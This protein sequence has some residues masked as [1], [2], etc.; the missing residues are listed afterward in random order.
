MRVYFSNLGCKLNQAEVDRMA[1]SFVAAGHQLA[2]ELEQADLHVINSCTVT[3]LAGRDSRKTARRG[4]RAGVRTVLTG[5]HAT[6]APE[7]AAGLGVDLVLPNAQKDELLERVHAAFPELQPAPGTSFSPY[8]P[9]EVGHQ[10]ALVKIEDGCNMGCAFCIIPSTRGRQQSR[11]PAEVLAEVEALSAAGFPEIVLTGVQ[12]SEYL[13]GGGSDGGGMRL[14]DLVLYL[15]AKSGVHRLRLTSIAPWRFDPRLLELYAHPRICRHIHLSLQSGST[16][17]LRRMRRPYSPE[18]FAA[19]VARLREAVPGIA[20]TT[21]IIVGFPGESMA[22]H[23]ESLAFALSQQFAKTHVFTYSPRPGTLAAELPGEV[24][25][26]EAKRR[27]HQQ[28]AVAA[29]SERA[30]AAQSVGQRLAVIWDEQRGPFSTGLADTSLR[31]FSRDKVP[32][33]ALEEVEVVALE[34]D[35]PIAER[36]STILSRRRVA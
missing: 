26:A 11:M 29:K 25:P 16:A 22:E 4:L 20:I 8:L 14:F 3:H 30:F 12:I 32:A 28:L 15:L 18:Q 21:D 33:G 19:L 7:A 6:A 13:G 2:A 5:C 23:E 10:R 34:G 24:A 36:R 27:V 31:V 9:V 17:T 35:R 1:R